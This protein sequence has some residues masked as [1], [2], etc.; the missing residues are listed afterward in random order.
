ME[1][2]LTDDQKYSNYVRLLETIKYIGEGNRITEDWMDEQM[3]IIQGYKIAFPLS[4]RVLNPEIK[5]KE[6]RIKAEQ[7][8]VLLN[9]LITSI[10]HEKTFKVGHYYMLL[11]RLL[12]MLH[13]ISQYYSDDGDELSSFMRNMSLG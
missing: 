9:S 10:Q 12:D 3:L 2:E 4:F 11:Q 7:A 5:D 6:F 8:D 1:V 13:H